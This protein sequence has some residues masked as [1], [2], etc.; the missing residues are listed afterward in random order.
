M[1]INLGME[2]P[3]KFKSDFLNNNIEIIGKIC[4]FFQ[5]LYLLNIFFIEINLSNFKF[6]IIIV[7]II[8]LILWIN[9]FFGE[10][11]IRKMYPK[12]KK[13]IYLFLPLLLI[14]LSVFEIIHAFSL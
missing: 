2:D 4:G 6:I 9:S 12:E 1:I 8:C 7:L 11:K 10:L 13:G 14:S 5:G 3:S